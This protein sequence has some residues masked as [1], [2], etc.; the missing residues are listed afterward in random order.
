MWLMLQQERPED[1]VIAT[2]SSHSL[3][4]LVEVAFAEVGL[5]WREH[6]D[7]DPALFRP[8]ELMVSR[9]DPARARRRLGWSATHGM[10]D[11]VR[12]MVEAEKTRSV[13]GASGKVCG[14]QGDRDE[15]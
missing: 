9:A 3:E 11:V 10:H 14:G 13:A 5:R 1:F 12:L 8:R 4:Q 7:I 2:G 15:R 6:V